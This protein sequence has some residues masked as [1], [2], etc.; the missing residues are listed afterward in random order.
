[1]IACFGIFR[2]RMD[3]MMQTMMKQSAATCLLLLTLSACSATVV[4]VQSS[5]SPTASTAMAS[6][7]PSPSPVSTAM[8]SASPSPSPAATPNPLC[9]PNAGEN[10]HGR[11]L[12]ASGKPVADAE[13]SLKLTDP[14]L[15][16]AC[17]GLTTQTTRSDGTYTFSAGSIGGAKYDLTIAKKGYVS[18][19]IVIVPILSRAGDSV[20]R[21][22][23]TLVTAP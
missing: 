6:A 13:L 9:D 20:N 16:A 17:P 10:V 15:L 21:F 2:K 11:V 4:T 8:A 1:M 12:D 5:P 18:Q 22:D 19:S 14:E 3:K 23:F 7:S